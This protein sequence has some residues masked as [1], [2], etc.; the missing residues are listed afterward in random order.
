MCLEP[1]SDRATSSLTLVPTKAFFSCYAA[2]KG[3]RVY[4]FEPEPESFARLLYNIKLNA[5]EDR[6]VARPWAI[7]DHAG[8][9]RLMVSRDCGGGTSTIVSRF[10]EN[11]RLS[12]RDVIAVPCYTLS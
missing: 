12:V 10:A 9:A 1:Q 8:S 7:A 6:V 2:H 11:A 3:A 4:A 5:L